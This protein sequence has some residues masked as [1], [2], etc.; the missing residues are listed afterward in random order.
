VNEKQR[1]AIKELEKGEIE[2][3]IIKATAL[4]LHDQ[5]DDRRNG[6]EESV[7]LSELKIALFNA[8]CKLWKTLEAEWWW[9]NDDAFQHR[10]HGTSGFGR[11]SSGA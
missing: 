6:L 5:A 1:K 4:A 7:E 3:V 9:S 11:N 8:K 2:Q 10:I